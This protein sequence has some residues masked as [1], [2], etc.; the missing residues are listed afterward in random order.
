MKKFL[1]ALCLCVVPV[2]A[3]AGCGSLEFLSKVSTNA[4]HAADFAYVVDNS[5]KTFKQSVLGNVQKSIGLQNANF[6]VSAYVADESAATIFDETIWDLVES[7]NAENMLAMVGANLYNTQAQNNYFDISFLSSTQSDFLKSFFVEKIG[8]SG[9]RTLYDAKLSGQEPQSLNLPVPFT[10]STTFVDSADN[11][12][13]QWGNNLRFEVAPASTGVRVAIKPAF[14]FPT[15][16]AVEDTLTQ[17]MQMQ[18]LPEQQM[19][20]LVYTF[21][22]EVFTKDVVFVEEEGI[23]KK[24]VSRYQ[25]NKIQNPQLSGANEYEYTLELGSQATLNIFCEYDISFSGA[26]GGIYCRQSPTGQNVAVISEYYVVK[27]G[28][29]VARIKESATLGTQK[30]TT[31]DMLI[32][33]NLSTGKIK[34]AF[35]RTGDTAGL[36]RNETVLTKNFCDITEYEKTLAQNNMISSVE[37]VSYEITET[38]FSVLRA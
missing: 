29:I 34:Y 32:N 37:I 19:V 25:G 17:D 14:S 8:T 27:S 35:Q 21:A 20:R 33:P 30:C 24:Y 2:V 26:D 11:V 36:L 10:S 9:T 6:D 38:K 22:D 7:T 15:Q 12:I 13:K 1:C 4:T 28:E 3:F 16:T 5:L 23:I 18:Y 31:I